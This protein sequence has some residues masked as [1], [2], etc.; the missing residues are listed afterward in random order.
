MTGIRDM[1]KQEASKAIA[2]CQKEID[3]NGFPSNG[4]HEN[5]IDW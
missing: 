3:E 1:T 4:G 5:L 2:E